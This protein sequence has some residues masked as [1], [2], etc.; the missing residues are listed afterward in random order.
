MEEK[1]RLYE[2]RR[3]EPP[4]TESCRMLEGSAGTDRRIPSEQTG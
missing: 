2:D 3:L 1:L 4:A